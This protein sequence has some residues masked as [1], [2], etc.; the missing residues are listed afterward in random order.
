MAE[1]FDLLTTVKGVM[2]PAIGYMFVECEVVPNNILCGS[3][4]QSNRG[5]AAPEGE[6]TDSR[7]NRRGLFGCFIYL[8]VNHARETS[9]TISP[10]F[11]LNLVSH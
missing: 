3:T 8:R 5:M 9:S 11:S 2:D 1:R 4:L 6:P 7:Q 10:I